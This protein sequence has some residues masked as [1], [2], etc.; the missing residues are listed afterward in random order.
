MKRPYLV[1][2]IGINHNGSIEL[3]KLLISLAKTYGIDAVK[4]QKRSPREC[5]PKD[6]WDIFKDTPFG[7]MKY[8]DYKERIEFGKRQYD[9]IDTHC[10]QNNMQWFPSI[11]DKTSIDFVIENY[12]PPF[13]KVP[14]A[15]ITDFELLEH[16]ADCAVPVILSTG[17]TTKKDIDNALKIIGDKTEY[18]L[19]CVSSYPTPDTEMNM[20]KLKS[21]QK[22]YGDDYKI[23]FSNHSVK[24]I[25]SVQAYVMGAE[26]LEFHITLDRSFKGTDH[27]ASLGPRG[28]EVLTNHIKSIT[29]GWGSGEMELQQSELPIVR[30]LRR[31]IK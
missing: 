4:F 7:E 21:L 25:Y 10:R 19:H 9:E 13:L 28:L 16:L 23:G 3:T 11:W 22:E 29:D 1:G 2:E 27:Q 8:I 6:Q 14:S 20:L 24:I 18:L 26:M 31:V 12:T 30:K 5:V 15:S 17:M